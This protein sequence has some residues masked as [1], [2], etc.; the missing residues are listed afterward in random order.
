M[1]ENPKQLTLTDLAIII[2]QDSI[3]SSGADP[4]RIQSTID[5]LSQPDF[6]YYVLAEHFLPRRQKEL[7]QTGLYFFPQPHENIKH[8][9]DTLIAELQSF[10]YLSAEEQTTYLAKINP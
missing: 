2:A 9:C 1:I 10:L 7:A 6:S 8:I 5:R 3:I 4:A